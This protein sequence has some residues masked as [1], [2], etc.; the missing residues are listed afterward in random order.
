MILTEARRPSEHP[1]SLIQGPESRR[2]TQSP[3]L[4]PQVILASQGGPTIRT[5]LKGSVTFHNSKPGPGDIGASKDGKLMHILLR[6]LS[7][8]SSRSAAVRLP[9]D[10]PAPRGLMRTPKKGTPSFPNLMLN[11]RK[12]SQRTREKSNAAGSRPKPRRSH[13]ETKAFE[14]LADAV[15]HKRVIPT[16]KSP[17]PVSHKTPQRRKK[18]NARSKV[19]IRVVAA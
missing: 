16:L 2:A 15:R 11:F 4:P 3:A 1:L 6:K 14:K 10:I 13:M 19:Q 12:D 17:A 18:L 9:R 5:S 7:S 8:P